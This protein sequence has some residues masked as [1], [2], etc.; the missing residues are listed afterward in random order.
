[1]RRP[2]RCCCSLQLQLQYCKLPLQVGRL[3]SN[4]WA[5]LVNLLRFDL[6]LLHFFPGLAGPGHVTRKWPKR[7][8][9]L[10][11]QLHFVFRRFGSCDMANK[12]K[13]EIYFYVNGSGSG[14]RSRSDSG[15][16]ISWKEKLELINKK[17]VFIYSSEGWGWQVWAWQAHVSCLPHCWSLTEAWKQTGGESEQQQR[18]NSCAFVRNTSQIA[19]CRLQT[20]DRWTGLQT[21]DSFLLRC[22]A[23][24]VQEA[25][26]FTAW[27]GWLTRYHKATASFLAREPCERKSKCL[28]RVID[29]VFVVTAIR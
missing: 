22:L 19:D 23:L 8:P 10:C 12:S 3:V 16:R 6:F 28:A 1:M 25:K 24:P 5:R 9:M 14:S 4:C 21:F 17:K 13:S 2:P 11:L 26:E 27:T 15:E 18:W 7:P 29:T 20:A